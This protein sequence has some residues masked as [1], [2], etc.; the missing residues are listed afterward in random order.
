VKC[1]SVMTLIAVAAAASSS[2]FA[3][4]DAVAGK[5]KCAFCA[6]CHAVTGARPANARP[7]PAGRN[8]GYLVKKLRA[9]RDG[10]RRDS[11][12]QPMARSLSDGHIDDLATYLSK[13][14]VAPC[15]GKSRWAKRHGNVRQI[16]ATI[17]GTTWR[18]GCA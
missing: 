8:Y 11:L 18:Q 7:N 10:S 17:S 15:A 2:R 9:F 16:T 13:Q 12:M 4:G 5:G 1:Q 14:A 3:S 6:T